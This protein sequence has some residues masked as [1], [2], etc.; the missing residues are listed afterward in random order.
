MRT[1]A[2]KILK[3]GKEKVINAILDDGSTQTFLNHDVACFLGVEDP[4]NRQMTVNLL[5]GGTE[6]LRT[7]TINFEIQNLNTRKKFA[8]TACTADNVCG[9]L[10][11]VNWDIK[12][13]DYDH[14]REIPFTAPSDKSKID[15]LIGLDYYDLQTSLAEVVGLPG[16][17]VARLTP[18][19]WTCVGN[20]LTEP[21]NVSE[22]S[23]FVRVYFTKGQNDIAEVRNDLEKKCEIEQNTEVRKELRCVDR[24]TL[25]K[26]TQSLR[27]PVKEGDLNEVSIPW[28]DERKELKCSMGRAHTMEC[29][30]KWHYY[31]SF[32][33]LISDL[34]LTFVLNIYFLY[35][36][37]TLFHLPPCSCNARWW[38]T[39]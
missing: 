28:K 4:R 36:F 24:D 10:E 12:K 21:V 7:N 35:W 9:E 25:E 29:Y 33:C 20:L 8:I 22:R 18:V 6:H 13:K 15:M 31:Q 37:V 11:A 5:N 3:N 39:A 26:M 27:E 14:L 23:H 34:G 32:W 19:G 2:I 17:P 38:A 30:T 16:E 1:V